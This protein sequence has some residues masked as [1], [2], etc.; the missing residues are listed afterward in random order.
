ML[1]VVGS[2]AHI[3]ARG[4]HRW[5]VVPASDQTQHRQQGRKERHVCDNV[6]KRPIKKETP[7]KETC[8]YQTVHEQKRKE[9]KRPRRAKASAWVITQTL[10]SIR[11]GHILTLMCVRGSQRA[12]E[13][14]REK[15]V[16]ERTSVCSCIS[17]CK[18]RGS[19]AT[20]G[21]LS[22]SIWCV[23]GVVLC[24][25]FVGGV[26]WVWFYSCGVCGAC[27]VVGPHKKNVCCVGC[28]LRGCFLSRERVCSRHRQESRDV[29]WCLW[30]VLCGV[31]GRVVGVVVAPVC[32]LA[33]WLCGSVWS[34]L[35]PHIAFKK[36]SQNLWHSLQFP[37]GDPI[38]QLC[39][40]RCHRQ[41]S[42][43]CLPPLA[44]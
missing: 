33:L 5:S 15:E 39:S 37:L 1:H 2:C 38:R 10:A 17:P 42:R 27:L 28:V 29:V 3:E 19:R 26:F 25:V 40:V 13:R 7:Q 8:E 4:G 30:V 24:V 35:F 14:E 9:R 31:L 44:T 32:A 21:F 16:K 11:L 43:F 36:C 22:T 20:D 23:L 34:S 12:R 18:R 6:D 41:V